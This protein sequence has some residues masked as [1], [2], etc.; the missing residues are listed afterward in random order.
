MVKSWE[1]AYNAVHSYASEILR[2]DNTNESN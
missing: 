1:E 2:E